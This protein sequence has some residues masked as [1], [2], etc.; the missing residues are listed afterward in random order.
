[1]HLVDKLAEKL[2]LLEAEIEPHGRSMA[3]VS[4]DVLGRH[5]RRP[6]GRFI[7]V[8]AMTPTYR[9]E[10]KTVTA[11]S[12]SMALN[13]LGKSSIATLR[14]P[15]AGLYF[16]L[17]GGGSGGGKAHLVPQDEID[18]HCTGDF[19]A[20]SM[21]HN[22]IASHLDLTA[23]GKGQE[24]AAGEGIFWKRAIDL[25]DR[26]LRDISTT[27]HGNTRRRSGFIMTPASEL[28]S[29]LS[30]CRDTDELKERLSKIIL[31]VDGDG[32]L[33]RL[34]RLDITDK[35]IRIL[36][37]ALLPNLVATSEHSPVLMHTGPFSNISHGNSSVLADEM[38]MRLADY[39]VTEGGGGTDT[40]LEKFFSLKSPVLGRMPDAAV[41]VVSARALKMHGLATLNNGRVPEEGQ[42]TRR[43][44]EALS[45][46]SM[47]MK[48]HIQNVKLFGLP[49][50]VAINRF[51]QDS[52]EELRSIK[53]MALDMGADFAVVHD[54][55]HTGSRGAVD[56]AEAVIEASKRPFSYR[57][58]YGEASS[59]EEK[60]SAVATG[61]YGAK[62]IR[63]SDTARAA[64]DRAEAL[65]AEVPGLCIAKTH[66][67]LSHDSRQKNIPP[68]FTLPI[69]DFIP[70][71]GAGYICALTEGINLMPGLSG[72]R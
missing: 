61:I 17:K 7:F 8:T 45:A 56:L 69:A 47:N 22:F 9:G 60:L 41:M 50:V 4:L 71:A 65:G 27:G 67:S 68:E 16:S 23:L 25:C 19:H 40:G 54:G 36:R 6:G 33:I 58:L 48:K 37:K 49:L 12:L 24:G 63:I 34:E 59:T 3:K 15:S 21:A 26:A 46:G 31:G 13:K 10:G 11:I 28:M 5:E 2:G 14:Q 38:A 32:S 29:I 51:S 70:F 20:I 1:M 18:M 62:G 43:N 57:L 44:D 66:L 30:L 39:V 42:W 64:L 53:S 52:R 35:V 72:R 55:W